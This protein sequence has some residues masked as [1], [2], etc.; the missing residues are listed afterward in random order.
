MKRLKFG[1][2]LLGLLLL[3]SCANEEEITPFR[4]K[5]KFE[6]IAVSSKLAGRINKL[7]VAEGDE[8]RKGDTLAFL[9]I[10]ELDAKMM[11]AEGALKA[12][13]GQLDMANTGATRE[14]LIQIEGKLD[15]ARAELAFARQSYSRLENMFKDSLVSG[16]QLDEVRMK[17][18]MANAQ[19]KALEAKHEESGKSVRAEQLDQAQGQVERARGAREEVLTAAGER[20][21]IAPANMSIETISLREGELLTPGYSLFTG[22]KKNSLYFRFT[23]NEGNIYDFEEGDE[24]LIL[25][26]YTKEELKARIASIRQLPKYAD[27]T[28]TA[29]L[30]DLSESVYELKVLPASDVSDQS[31]YSN[32]TVLL[33]E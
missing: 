9:D 28:T 32:A 29:P 23:I 30:Y 13:R 2:I 3:T 7:Y 16:Q 26:P 6:S 24:L 20:Y 25:N 15:A 10:P 11:Q 19:V 5:V 27:I 4:G 17:L 21:L 18:Q 33:K 1:T 8:V 14:Q 22:Y 12:A 31:F